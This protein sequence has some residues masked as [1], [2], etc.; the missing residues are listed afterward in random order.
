MAPA[1]RSLA[2]P[3][4]LLLLGAFPLGLYMVGLDVSPSRLR[5]F[6]YHKWIGVT[7]F[8]VAVLRLGWHLWSPRPALPDAMPAWERR[9]AATVHRLLYL[10][11][12]AVPLS[13]WLM[14]SA[15]G[16]QTVYF[17]VL[18][19]PDALGKNAALGAALEEVHWALNKMLLFAV[20]LHIAAALKHH[21][22]DRDGILLRMLPRWIGPE[23]R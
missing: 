4:P 12:L 19:I 17:A 1:A 10:L 3:S 23:H 20:C 18:P 9:A 21:Y 13:G 16:F 6:A 15:K 14:S 22:L 5:L 8:A 2:D 7:V 11:V